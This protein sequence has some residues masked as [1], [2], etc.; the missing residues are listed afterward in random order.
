MTRRVARIGEA[1]AE[2][3]RRC[4]QTPD[5]D[6]LAMASAIAMTQSEP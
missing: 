1:I 6:E 4:P 5:D 2:S 3:Y